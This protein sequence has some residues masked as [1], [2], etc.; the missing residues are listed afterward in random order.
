MYGFAAINQANGW[1]MAGAGACIVLTGLAVLS[2]LIS[3]IPRLT[4]LFEAKAPKPID[5]PKPKTAPVRSEPQAA[6]G[7]V[8]AEAATY[9]A[10]T[11]DL[12]TEFNLVDVH[13]KS[14]KAGLA[15][16][17]LSISRFRDAGILIP[18]GDDRFSWQSPSQ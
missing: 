16:P 1:A 2:F 12:G 14:R 3:M 13:L 8:S 15:H 4:A 6:L 17:H 7:D 9:M 11:E 10:L 5:T 18:V